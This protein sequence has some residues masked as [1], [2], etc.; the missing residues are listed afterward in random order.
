MSSLIGNTMCVHFDQG[1]CLY[2]DLCIKQHGKKDA[3]PLCTG[4]KRVR[5]AKGCTKCKKCDE[6]EAVDRPVDRPCTRQCNH[7]DECKFKERCIFLHNDE[8]AV[9]GTCKSKCIPDWA[10]SCRDCDPSSWPMAYK[11]CTLDEDEEEGCPYG[12]GKCYRMHGM[13]DTRPI[14]QTCYKV[15]LQVGYKYCRQC[16]WAFKEA[17]RGAAAKK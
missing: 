14:C 10:E 2:A 1:L 16:N 5:I 11:L 9:C 6:E 8:R 12:P 17:K 13:D 3:R 4:C 7:M 15:R